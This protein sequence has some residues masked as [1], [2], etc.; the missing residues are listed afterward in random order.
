MTKAEKKR[1]SSKA[2]RMIC[3]RS[4]SLKRADQDVG[5]ENHRLCDEHAALSEASVS[6]IP[7]ILRLDFEAQLGAGRQPPPEGFKARTSQE[8]VGRMIRIASR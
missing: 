4:M 5:V 6:L 8:I 1:K 3:V 7:Q 2:E